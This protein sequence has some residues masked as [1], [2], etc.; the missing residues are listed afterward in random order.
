MLFKLV[1]QTRGM[2]SL[3]MNRMVFEGKPLA[4]Q[5]WKATMLMNI[6]GGD[7]GSPHNYPLN[8]FSG[9]VIRGKVF[10]FFFLVISV[11]TSFAS[12][13]VSSHIHT[14]VYCILKKAIFK[15]NN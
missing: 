9:L 10:F 13:A 5:K 14:C 1:N 4:I 7:E 15:R 6:M 2:L 8:L 12:Y 11:F 3:E